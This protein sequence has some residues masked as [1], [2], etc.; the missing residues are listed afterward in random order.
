MKAIRGGKIH[1]IS[2]GV[3]DPGDVLVERGKI[4][5][6][7][8][9]LGLPPGCEVTEVRGMWVTPGLIDPHTHLGLDEEGVWAERNELN[10]MGDPITPHL[11]AVD[12]F[13]AGDRAILQA[14]R[15]GVTA[16]IAT[17]G[18]IQVLSGQA[19]AIRLKPTGRL[20]DMLLAAPV[21]IK[22]GWRPE[23]SS[24]TRFQEEE[25]KLRALVPLMKREI[26]WRV[27]AHRADDILT[28]LRVAG[29]FGFRVVIE[30]GTE[31][32]LLAD[33][34]A[35]AG[36]MVV[37]GPGGFTGGTKQESH[38]PTLEHL[39]ELIRAG[40]PFAFTTD[41][42][43]LPLCSLPLLVGEAVSR[44]LLE[45]KV[46]LEALT[47]GA[48][49]IL[50]MEHRLGSLDVGKDADLVVADGPILDFRTRVRG[51]MVDGEWVVAPE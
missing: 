35:E 36:A 24:S 25:M 28:A 51:V 27:H 48:A 31:A 37:L 13:W 19:A 20:K 41:H 22:G 14:V 11:R 21:G 46:A 42:P 26:P 3:L 32:P 38:F 17:T 4:A 7:G 16:V 50:G 47:M 45:E 15:A 2:H 5:A 43:V 1:T 9:N 12:G 44:G 23:E 40:V 49:V 10:E 34:L 30:H 8:S 33:E 29:E 18:S 6:V 39:R